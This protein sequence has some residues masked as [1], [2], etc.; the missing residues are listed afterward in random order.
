MRPSHM[1]RKTK[2]IQGE[3]IAKRYYENQGCEILET[4]Y[5]YLRA[6][7][8]FI[9]LQDEELLIFVEVKNRSRRDFGEAETFVS[10]AQQN[11]IK[12]AAEEYIFGINWNKDIRFDIVCVDSSGKI[13]VFEDAF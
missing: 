13:E 8:D 10:A 5:R 12:D 9:A 2:G 7:I 11:R 3:G 4:N 6:E 1:D